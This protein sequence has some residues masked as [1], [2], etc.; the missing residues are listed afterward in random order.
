MIPERLGPIREVFSG[1]ARQMRENSLQARTITPD[2]VYQEAN[3]SNRDLINLILDDLALPGSGIL[4]PEQ[5]DA[6]FEQSMNGCSALL[7]MEHYSNF[8]LPCLFYLVNRTGRTELAESFI[9]VAGMKLNEESSFVNAFAEA[10]TRIVIYP[11]RSLRKISDPNELAVETKRSR[12]INM[13]ATRMM[14]RMKHKGRPLLV[15]PSG[16][17]YREGDPDTKRGVKEIDSYIKSFDTMVMIGVSG[18]CLTIN[19]TA[20]GDMSLDIATRD[21]V[22]LSVS[23]PISCKEFRSRARST[24]A[25]NSD[26]KQHVA[27]LVMKELETVHAEAAAHRSAVISNCRQ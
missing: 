6:L 15:F 27:D 10:Y 9:A 23:Q 14:I 26:P 4:H 1:H 18:N 2:A 8:D 16:T 13:A 22:V 11:S 7:L 17:R 19:A 3:V 24:A 21:I 12:E 20:G 5:L 25:G